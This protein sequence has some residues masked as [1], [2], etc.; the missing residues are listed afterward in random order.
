MWVAEDGSGRL[1]SSYEHWR[2][3]GPRD[4]ARWEAAGSPDLPSG[5][6]DN[7]F[8][9]G[10]LP[11]VDTTSLPTRVSRLEGVLRKEV[12][13]RDVPEDVAVFLRV[14]ELLSR[15]DAPPPLRAALYRV[16]SRLPGVALVGDRTDPNGRS[17]IA[18]G[19]TY[20][21]SGARIQV[22]MIFD[23]ETSALL[24]QERFLLERAAW[25]DAAPGTR[26]SYVTYLASER[27]DSV[28]EETSDG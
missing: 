8:P 18:V 13:S 2:F 7:T 20:G 25:I 12:E 24:S 17:G 5:V 3:V 1:R 21:F 14:G 4:V 10:T 15:N 11:Y 27:V 9:A 19:M 23:E 26:I 6:S 28:Q 16:T 22:L